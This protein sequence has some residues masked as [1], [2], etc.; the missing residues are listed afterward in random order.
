MENIR[1]GISN[2]RNPILVSFA[3]KGLLPYHGLG[4]GIKR[5]LRPWRALDFVDDRERNQF[6]ATVRREGLYAAEA[7]EHVVAQDDLRNDP[8]NDPLSD[9]FAAIRRRPDTKIGIAEGRASI[10]LRSENER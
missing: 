1:G 8:T 4:S 9:L 7:S 6:V 3:S 5:A 10:L 2:I